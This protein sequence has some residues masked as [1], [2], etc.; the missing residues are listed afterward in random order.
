MPST[1]GAQ[2]LGERKPPRSTEDPDQGVSLSTRETQE[3]LSNY[4][5][6]ET[7]RDVAQ[8]VEHIYLALS[9]LVR[10]GG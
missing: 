9:T 3:D 10:S 8:E 2:G 1:N 5:T 6:S 4:E 7:R